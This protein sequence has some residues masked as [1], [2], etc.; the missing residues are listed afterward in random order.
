MEDVVVCCVAKEKKRQ[1]HN[2]TVVKSKNVIGSNK[3]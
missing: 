2:K 3:N 1:K